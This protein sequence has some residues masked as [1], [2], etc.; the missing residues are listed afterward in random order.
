MEKQE[1][2]DFIISEL[3][4]NRSEDEI[5]AELSQRLGAPVD[6]VQ[7]FVSR[8]IAS[9]V[10]PSTI[11]T[12]DVAPVRHSPELD[13]PM[14]EID[15]IGQDIAPSEAVEI[16]PELS[17]TPAFEDLIA[18]L[19]AAESEL[20]LDEESQ[21]YEQWSKA[22]E[23]QP[24]DYDEFDD[25][26]QQPYGTQPIE[27][28]RMREALGEFPEDLGEFDEVIQPENDLGIVDQPLQEQVSTAPTPVWD[29][30]ALKKE[31]P[32]PVPPE[33]DTALERAILAALSRQQRHS[34]VVLMVCEKT[35]LSWDQAQ[36]LV[37]NVSQ[38]N[39]KR[40][41]RRGGCLQAFVSLLAILAGLGLLYIVGRELF[42]FYQ[43]YNQP[44]AAGLAAFAAL[45]RT[46]LLAGAAGVLL[47]LV[48]TTGMLLGIR[49]SIN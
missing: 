47:F 33:Q 32:Q 23:S 25:G 24:F 38:K 18:P 11:P 12:A 46:T 7:R 49:K 3:S 5:V 6:I 21:P 48:G 36:Q 39:R 41:N 22:E 1:A 26:A 13:I 42:A 34:D 8:T 45:N 15:A 27:E 10:S 17:E 31:A 4:Q 19:S 43:V 14:T 20:Q 35:G 30:D 2:I 37:A 44:Q 16:V 28:S 40:L 29:P 9:Q